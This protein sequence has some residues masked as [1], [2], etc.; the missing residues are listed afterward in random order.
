MERDLRDR[1]QTILEVL[2]ELAQSFDVMIVDYGSQDD[3]V[4]V[5]WELV[6]TFPQVEFLQ[7][8]PGTDLVGAIEAGLLETQGEI[9]FVH[10]P[11]Q[12]LAM[13]ALRSLWQLRDDDDL[14]MAQ[15]RASGEAR[16]TLTKLSSGRRAT[17]SISSSIQMIRR[18][19]IGP[20]RRPV[21][22]SAVT[23]DRVTRTDL[24][25][26]SPESVRLPKL[27]TRLRHLSGR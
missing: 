5:A 13:S 21:P 9:V 1:V 8:E 18:Q 27:L 6:R 23:V 11:N 12:V 20:L 3:T 7:A 17:P 4:E 24:Q 22:V 25:G 26:E 10:D 15:S 19:A 2:E 16:P 14:V